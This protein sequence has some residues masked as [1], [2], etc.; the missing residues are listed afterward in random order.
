M[1][2]NKLPK[3]LSFPIRKCFLF[4][5]GLAV[6][7]LQKLDILESAHYIFAAVLCYYIFGLE[8]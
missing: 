1:S 2:G 8:C 7:V 6:S 3:M 4:S 5:C